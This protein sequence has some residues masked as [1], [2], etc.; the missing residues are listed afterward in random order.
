MAEKQSEKSILDIL[1]FD[2]VLQEA[3]EIEIGHIC[4]RLYEDIEK[5]MNELGIHI[6]LNVYEGADV[7]IRQK[8]YVIR[9][10]LNTL[11]YYF[12][13]MFPSLKTFVISVEE[14]DHRIWIAFY[15]EGDGLKADF[16]AQHNARNQNLD[17]A[18]EIVQQYM[19]QHNICPMVILNEDIWKLGMGFE[20][21]S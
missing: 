19:Q 20:F 10:C 4:L 6:M 2:A 18:M 17:Y 7:Y 5:A 21:I 1:S 3:E 16:E 12:V 13:C 15:G 11:I 8:E 9:M 14:H